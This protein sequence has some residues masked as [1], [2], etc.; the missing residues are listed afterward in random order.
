M[1]EERSHLPGAQSLQNLGLL[2]FQKH[3]PWTPTQ[4]KWIRNSG[5][6]TLIG[7]YVQRS[8]V[9]PYAAKCENLVCSRGMH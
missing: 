9:V 4:E 7:V 8:Q 5:W 2:A 1:N 3:C 6:G